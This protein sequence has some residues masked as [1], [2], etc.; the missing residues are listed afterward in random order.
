[1]QTERYLNKTSF[2]VCRDRQQKMGW[3]G[4]WDVLQR[5]EVSGRSLPAGQRCIGIAWYS[6]TTAYFQ[7][8]WQFHFVVPGDNSILKTGY[9]TLLCRVI[10]RPQGKR[11]SPEQRVSLC[12]AES[13]FTSEG[14]QNP[15]RCREAL[16]LPWH[17]FALLL[18]PVPIV[19]WVRTSVWPPVFFVAPRWKSV[20]FTLIETI[21]LQKSS[22]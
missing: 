5:K 3:L 17:W 16:M 2:L 21:F 9:F 7:G 6:S 15:L 18:S 1:M 4:G 22:H 11:P 19:M 12:C 10:A 13:I 14:A 8:E 20:K